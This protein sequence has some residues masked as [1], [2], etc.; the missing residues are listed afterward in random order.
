MLF[1]S[2]DSGSAAGDPAL[3]LGPLNTAGT[4]VGADCSGQTNDSWERNSFIVPCDANGDIYYE[5]AATGAS[6]MDIHM[7]IWGYYI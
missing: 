4:G 7:R 3:T 5:V 2:R 1:R 6:T